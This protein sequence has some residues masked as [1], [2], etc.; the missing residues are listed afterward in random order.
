[1]LSLNLPLKEWRRQSDQLH[2]ALIV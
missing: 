1:M 2:H